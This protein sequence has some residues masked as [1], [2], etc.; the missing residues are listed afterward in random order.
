MA[1]SLRDVS[2]QKIA[3]FPFLDR[4]KEIF[5]NFNFTIDNIIKDFEKVL[6]NSIENLKLILQN[7]DDFSDKKIEEDLIEALSYPVQNGIV[8]YL[9]DPWFINRY[10]EAFSRRTRKFFEANK[11]E[12]EILKEWG[13]N[14]IEDMNG[15]D[16][17]KMNVF[18]FLSFATKIRS[19]DLKPG[20]DF[21]QF[22]K[23]FKL[24]NNI[25]S[26]GWVEQLTRSDIS[27]LLT[28]A[29]REHVYNKVQELFEHLK[30][31]KLPKQIMEEADNLKDLILEFKQERSIGEFYTG[32]V[33]N[34]AFP[35]CINNG[36]VQL[37]AGKNLDH[38]ER[39][40]FEFFCLNI[41]MT[42]EELLNLFAHSPD[43][44]KD[45]TGYMVGHAE[46]KQYKSY[47]CKKI[48]SFGLCKINTKNDPY[49]WCMKGK[50]KNPL[51]YFSWMANW[52][53][54]RIIP[55]MLCFPFL[56]MQKLPL[57]LPKN[58][59][60]NEK[61]FTRNQLFYYLKRTSTVNKKKN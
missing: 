38:Q 5:R 17:F 42:A 3:Q 7:I 16:T 51:T 44:R 43:F 2:W 28:A 31:S 57:K 10:S 52:L 22:S 21:T 8:A 58:I 24:V 1:M 48:K 23:R 20:M 9:H 25:V 55:N 27:N 61:P 33:Y 18:D 37:L 14:I 19:S 54:T 34:D 30:E 53:E 12:I 60:K 49:N 50:I 47:G 36:H 39:L 45:I 6:P 41:G 11:N 56:F 35:S 32:T 46:K 15:K 29:L 40:I 59:P 26:E 4:N 13:I